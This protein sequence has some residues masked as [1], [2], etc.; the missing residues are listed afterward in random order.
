LIYRIVV[1]LGVKEKTTNNS[2]RS[3]PINE[4]KSRNENGFLDFCEKQKFKEKFLVFENPN[5]K[6]NVGIPNTFM[7]ML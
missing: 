2:W 3:Q 6:K 5:L 7:K 4:H 1:P